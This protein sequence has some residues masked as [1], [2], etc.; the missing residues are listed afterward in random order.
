MTRCCICDEPLE[1]AQEIV[2][3]YTSLVDAAGRP[4]GR[5]T[6][7]GREAHLTCVAPELAGVKDDDLI[8]RGLEAYKTIGGCVCADCAERATG[9]EPAIRAR[10]LGENDD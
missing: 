10:A 2:A 4:V 5:K 9:V 6:Y 3:E 8:E 1:E 7:S